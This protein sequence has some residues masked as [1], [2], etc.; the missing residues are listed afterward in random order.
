MQA[1]TPILQLRDKCYYGH[2]TIRFAVFDGGGNE[3]HGCIFRGAGG[4][5]LHELFPL[6]WSPLGGSIRICGQNE[7]TSASFSV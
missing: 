3:G 5:I 1:N 2:R 4:G 7:I 6:K